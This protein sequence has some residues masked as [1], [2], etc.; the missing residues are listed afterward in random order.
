MRSLYED[1]FPIRRMKLVDAYGDVATQ[2]RKLVLLLL[3]E[4]DEGAH[5]VACVAERSLGHALLHVLL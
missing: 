2:G 4:A 5:E 1:R 3:I